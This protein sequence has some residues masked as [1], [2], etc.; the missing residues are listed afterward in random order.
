MSATFLYT[1]Y[2]KEVVMHYTHL[3][4]EERYTIWTLRKLGLSIRAVASALGRSPSTISRELRRN[5][6]KRGYRAR[7]AHELGCARRQICRKPTKLTPEVKLK[8]VSRLFARW[9]PEQIAGRL[10]LEGLHRIS[11]QTIY[12]YIAENRRTGGKLYR[13]LRRRGKKYRAKGTGQRW[14]GIN[15]RKSID[16][17]PASVETRAVVGDWEVDTLVT[18][19]DRAVLLSLVERKSRFTLL[20]CLSNKQA[21]P[22]A[23]KIVSL[24]ARHRHARAR[25]IT[26]D[27]GT[28]FASFRY[29]E[30]RLKIDFYFAHPYSSWERGTNENTNGLIREYF[31]KS[32]DFSDA[33]RDRLRQVMDNLNNRPRKVLGYRT[34][35]ELLNEGS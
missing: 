20:A 4:S 18:R 29:V 35:K 15:G 28:E 27:N 7:K 26:S 9:S 13:F 16:E 34:P 11:H 17:R 19:K 25:T 22:I 3:T 6:S 14:T 33:N 32:S 1:T 5:V 31:P 21:Y 8:I 10:R 2:I 30:N 23:R 12:T 24:L